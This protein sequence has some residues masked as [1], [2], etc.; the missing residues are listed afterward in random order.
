[1]VEKMKKYSFL[2]YH[3]TYPDFLE[4]IRRVGVVHII[5][6]QKGI[7]DDAT[8]LHELLATAD[9]LKNTIYTLEHRLENKKLKPEKSIDYKTDG[10]QTMAMYEDLK[11]QRDRFIVQQQA[12]LKEIEQMAVWGNFDPEIINKFEQAG[13][14]LKFFSCRE[15]EFQS[16]W[17]EQFE[18]VEILRSNAMVYFVA[19]IP[20][21]IEDE[22]DAEMMCI[23][24]RS[25]NQL[26]EALQEN[27]IQIKE[28]ENEIDIFAQQQLE[29]LK[30]AY[31]QA[32]GN[33]DIDKVHLQTEK[34]ADN[35][36]ILLEGWAPETK[37]PE[38]LRALETQDVFYCSKIPDKTDN[39]VPILLKNNVLTRLFEPIGEL[40]DLP[41]YHELDLTPFFAPFYML[42]FGLC[43]GDAGYGLLLLVVAL[44][45]RLKV[46]PSLKPMLSLVAVLGGAAFVCGTVVGTLFGIS[47]LDV[48]WQWFAS[49]KKFMLNSDQLFNLALI[50][51]GVQII[52]GMFVKAIGTVRRYGFAYSLATWGWIIL[53]L[54]GGGVYFASEKAL[55]EPNLA[56]YLTF[57]ILGIS[58]LFIFILNTPKRNPIRNIGAGLWSAYQIATGVLSDLLSYIRLFALGICGGVMGFVFNNLALHISG[59]IPVVSHLVMFI[60]LVVG[61]ALNIFI[62]G[63]GAF[64]HPLRLTFVEF[65]KNAGFEGGGKKYTPLKKRTTTN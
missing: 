31:R 6:K 53:F 4:C 37:E 16:K 51:G 62:S 41:N 58:C 43:L 38:L 59:D 7:P 49:F 28:I 3:K 64:A 36:L 65:Y 34:R 50:L 9:L 1:M 54:G 2:I 42:F 57:A 29:N 21:G 63:L 20:V 17:K 47:L 22:P 52:F 18:I 44:I 55:L 61:H 12:L 48:Q 19:F 30:N 24:N 46:K 56:R 40:Y 60:I 39:S 13:H 35:K 33:I 26:Q 8:H 14:Q 32:L 15:H 45:A 11:T 10:L 5:E 23:S 27:Q 25:L